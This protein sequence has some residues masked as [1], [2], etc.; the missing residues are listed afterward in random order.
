MQAEEL[1]DQT[2][3]LW[4]SGVAGLLNKAKTI[5]VINQCLTQNTFGVLKIQMWVCVCL[6]FVCVFTMA[7]PLQFYTQ[8]CPL[9]LLS[10]SF[11]GIM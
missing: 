11:A 5:T 1:T 10:L 2:N 3:S 9:G 6:E 4:D 7:R 8:L